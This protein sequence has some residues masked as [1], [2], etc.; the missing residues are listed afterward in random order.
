M[1]QR[2]QT[3]VA[4]EVQVDLGK[5]RPVSKEETV[6]LDARLILLAALAFFMPG[7]VVGDLELIPIQMCCHQDQHSMVRGMVG[8]IIIVSRKRY[9]SPEAMLSRIRVAA[10]AVPEERVMVAPVVPASSLCDTG[11]LEPLIPF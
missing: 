2:K 1:T 10:A 3:P 11:F 7:V 9:T 5:T 4:V 8:A 6:A